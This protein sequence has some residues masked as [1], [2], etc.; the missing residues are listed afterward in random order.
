MKFYV[1]CTPVVLKV[2]SGD[3]QGS[4]RWLQGELKKICLPIE[5]VNQMDT[6]NW[7]PNWTLA[8]HLATFDNLPPGCHVG[9]PVLTFSDVTPAVDD[10]FRTGR[11]HTAVV[12]QTHRLDVRSEGNRGVHFQHSFVVTPPPP[13]I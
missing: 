8:V 5:S 6:L 7:L 2:G 9:C 1:Y 11:K 4:L 10:A 13:A 12:C 3:L